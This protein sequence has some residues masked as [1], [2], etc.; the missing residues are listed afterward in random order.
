MFHASQDFLMFILYIKA[1]WLFIPP[2]HSETCRH[3]NLV[4]KGAMI[5]VNKYAS[6]L[7]PL[8]FFLFITVNHSHPIALS[9][10]KRLIFRGSLFSIVVQF[11]VILPLNYSLSYQAFFCWEIPL[12]WLSYDVVPSDLLLIFVVWNSVVWVSFSFLIFDLC[13]FVYYAKIK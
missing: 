5:W 9:H 2:S 10:Q 7:H 6:I 4:V 13:D 8:G 3:I 12:C 11:V 1:L